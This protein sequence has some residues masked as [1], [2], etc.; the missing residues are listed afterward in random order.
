MPIVDG[1]V[2]VHCGSAEE[3]SQIAASMDNLIATN[4]GG[5]TGYVVQGLDINVQ[6][7]FDLTPPAA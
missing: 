3:V 4:Q 7:Y 1:T 2:A 5:V 6:V